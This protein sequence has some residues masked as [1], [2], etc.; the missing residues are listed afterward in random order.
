VGD[1]NPDPTYYYESSFVRYDRLMELLEQ[2][3]TFD[4]DACWAVLSDTKG[5]EANSNTISA[6]GGFGGSST[7]FGTVHTPDGLYYVLGR[8]DAY[9]AEY[10]EPQFVS[11][12]QLPS[13][14]RFFAIPQSGKV[15]LRWKTE[16]ETQNAGFNL[17]RGKSQGGDF[18]KINGSL[19]QPKR[20][21]PRGA[22]YEYE[23]TSVQNRGTYY[24]KLEE[25]DLNGVSIVHGTVNATPRLFYGNIQ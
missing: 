2:T 8:P 21:S 15:L 9:L 12:S 16:T 23:D 1:F 18:V 19:I 4:L 5:G 6:K 13:I 20:S 22:V 14:I 25:I 17:Y 11:F 10:S 3:E 24:Y 7:V